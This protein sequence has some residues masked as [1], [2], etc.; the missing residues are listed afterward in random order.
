MFSGRRPLYAR[1]V[2]FHT[3]PKLQG[4]TDNI[5]K[6]LLDALCGVVYEDDRVIKRCVI[7]VVHFR[8]IAELDLSI[9]NVP[10]RPAEHLLQVLTGEYPDVVYIEVGRL[11][12]QRLELGSIP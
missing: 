11:I 10:E 4:D 2:H 1:I 5:A 7:D 3:Y 12:L 6:P 9:V 8:E